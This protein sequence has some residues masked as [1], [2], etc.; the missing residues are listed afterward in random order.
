M[1]APDR[2]YY[3]CPCCGAHTLDEAETGES[4]TLCKWG[5]PVDGYSLAEARENVRSYGIM[6]RPSDERF[7][8]LRHP[9]FGPSGE[10]AIDRVVLRQRVYAEFANAGKDRAEPASLS[11]RLRSLLTIVRNADTLYV[12]RS[13]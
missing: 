2:L 8:R 5:G 10:T 3:R 9:I 7:A 4:C 12:H 1:S 6:Y 13:S 11:E